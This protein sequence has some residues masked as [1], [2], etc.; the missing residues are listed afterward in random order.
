MWPVSAEPCAKPAWSTNTGPCRAGVR[1]IAAVIDELAA[2]RS[3]SGI[4][5]Q[6]PLPDG[7]DS[8]VFK[9]A[10]A[11]VAELDGQLGNGLAAAVIN[12]LENMLDRIT[13]NATN[14]DS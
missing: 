14:A 7:L 8:A 3:V 11:K 5:L 10:D 12:H 13:T 6:L 2:D 4:L 9:R 1:T